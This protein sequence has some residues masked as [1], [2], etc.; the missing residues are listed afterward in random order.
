MFFDHFFFNRYLFVEF[1]ISNEFVLHVHFRSVAHESGTLL[2]FLDANRTLLFELKIN[3]NV[4]IKYRHEN[5]T[6][7]FDLYRTNLI[8]NDGL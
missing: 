7:Q 6:K 8:A 1:Q 5:R 3:Q 4:S 2:S